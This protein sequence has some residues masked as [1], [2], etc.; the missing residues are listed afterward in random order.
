M[1]WM[2]ARGSGLTRRQH[3]AQLFLFALTALALVN[4]FTGAFCLCLLAASVSPCR[5]FLGMDLS[6]LWSFVA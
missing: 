4:V 2:P 1:W 6:D 5:A 3:V